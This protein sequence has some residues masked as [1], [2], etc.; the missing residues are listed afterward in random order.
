MVASEDKL[1]AHSSTSLPCA[2]LALFAGAS[3]AWGQAAWV[4]VWADEFDG[5]SLSTSNW[6]V[7][8][9]TGSL[10]GLDNWGN[11]ELQYYTGRTANLQVGGGL[12]TITARQENFGGRSYTSARIRSLGRRDFLYGKFEARISVPAGAG[13]WPAF[14]MLPTNSPYGG[15]ASSGEIDIIETINAADIAYGTLHYG[16]AWPNNVS[17]GGQRPGVWSNSFHDYRVEWE[18]D[19][20]RWY[21]DGVR[22]HRVTSSTW[23]S[24]NAPANARAPFDSP[25]HLLLNLA[26][27]G[28]WPG[29]PDGSTVFPAQM[30]VDY[31]RVSQ[32]PPKGPYAGVV[33]VLPAQIEAEAFDRGGASVAYFDNEPENQGNGYRLDEG[34]DIQACAE[35]G[36]NVGW[37]QPGEWMEY[38]VDVPRAGTYQLR[39]R[40]ATPA[41]GAACRLSVAG[42]NVSSQINIP[43][44]AGWQTYRSVNMN[45][46]LAA[47]PQSMRLTN[48]GASGADVNVNWLS[49]TVA[50][51]VDGSGGT[52]LDDLYTYEQGAGPYR[53]VDGDGTP[54]TAFDRAALV[55]ILRGQ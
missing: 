20:I 32:R 7:Q 31:V 41:A 52:N 25:F 44:T 39:L 9:G 42:Q 23:F 8:T 27:G 43:A 15:W 6:E 17:S 55:T 54:G 14:W 19:E 13:I 36:W 28:N 53:D 33:P 22:Y 2:L 5:T 45:V 35:G 3:V 4:P 26:V 30:K 21:V 37:F 12:L 18:P 51:D 49:L 29:P 16:N 11:N 10:Y 46:V 47:G 50:G 24:S 34:V 40:V 38:S 1:P 48:T